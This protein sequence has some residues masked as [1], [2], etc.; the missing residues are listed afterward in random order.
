[1][2]LLSK[3]RQLHAQH[4]LAKL[5]ENNKRSYEVR[6]FRER[7]AAALKATRGATI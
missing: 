3:L 7:R 1:M 5:V 2:N 4:K 6:R